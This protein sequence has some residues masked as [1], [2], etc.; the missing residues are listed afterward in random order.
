[1]R[2]AGPDLG[3]APHPPPAPLPPPDVAGTRAADAAPAR[4]RRR[5]WSELEHPGLAVAH[6][7]PNWF[8]AVMGTGVVAVAASSLPVRAPLRATVA[9]AALDALALVAWVAAALLLLVLLVASALHWTRHPAT[10]REYA[11]HP[12][13]ANFYGAPAMGLLTVGAGAHLVGE[14][15]VGPT[16]GLGVFAGLWVLGTAL[17]LATAVLVPFRAVVAAGAA[18]GTVPGGTAPTA[19]PGALP[20]WMMPVVPPMVSASTGALLVPEVPA[21]Q[22]RL[23]FLLLLAALF[24]LSLVAGL[25]TATLVH[26]RLLTAGPLP[27]QAAPTTWITLGVVGQSMTAALLLG[28]ATAGVADAPVVQVVRV[29]GVVYAAAMGGFGALLLVLAAALTAHAARRGLRFS[30]T[31]WSFTFPVGTCVTGASA[32]GAATGSLAVDALAVALFGLLL[33]AWAVVAAR[34]ARGAATGA[35]LLPARG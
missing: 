13:M 32:L 22:L 15:L 6:L 24:G 35:L 5:P 27:V 11:R 30:L 26:G 14:R 25:M 19:A 12:V 17:G 31:W 33:L 29:L 10:A 34:T 23:A 9:G 7:T 18:A 8:A 16:A 28:A 3:A 1:V 4:A 21:G 20:A 2:T